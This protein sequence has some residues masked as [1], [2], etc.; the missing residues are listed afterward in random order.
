MPKA[1]LWH[2]DARRRGRPRL[3]YARPI[4]ANHLEFFDTP[5]AAAP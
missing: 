1:R 5:A 4:G 3:G 2:D